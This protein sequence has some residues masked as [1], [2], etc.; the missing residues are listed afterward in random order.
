VPIFVAILG[1]RA[2]DNE[3]AN[4]EALTAPTG[5]TWVH[6]PDVA[7]VAPLLTLVIAN[8]TQNQVTYRSL[9]NSSGG[10]QIALSLGGVTSEAQ[11]EITVEPAAVT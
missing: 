7:E 11:F 3:I 10:H 1:A 8:R 2:D 4:M 5:G 9:V 6:M